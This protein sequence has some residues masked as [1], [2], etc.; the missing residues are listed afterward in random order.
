VRITGNFNEGVMVADGGRPELKKCAV[1][2]SRGGGLR[3][4][5]Q[6]QGTVDDTE[7]LESE[8]TGIEIEAGAHPS[9]R[10][11]RVLRG[12]GAGVV[13]LGFGGGAAEKCEVSGNAG[14]DWEIAANARLARAD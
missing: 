3:F 12:K 13:V 8:G 9:L 14:G 10:R 4:R 2:Q 1:N 7:V 5:P 11:V 6:G